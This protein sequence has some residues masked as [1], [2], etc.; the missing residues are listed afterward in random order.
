MSPSC[1]V[2]EIWRLKDNVNYTWL[3]RLTWRHRSRDQCTKG[4]GHFFIGGQ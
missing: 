4:S 2:M 1:T 3:F